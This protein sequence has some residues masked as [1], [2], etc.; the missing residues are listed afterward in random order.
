[1]AGRAPGAELADLAADEGDGVWSLALSPPPPA[2]A[3]SEVQVS[4]RDRQGNRTR[5]VR[6]F[7]AGG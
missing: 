1:V 4:V 6:R 3:T 5:V 7:R 2:G